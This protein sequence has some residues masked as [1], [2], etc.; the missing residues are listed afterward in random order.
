MLWLLLIGRIESIDGSAV[1][2]EDY[3]P[4]DQVVDFGEGELEKQVGEGFI[5]S[6]LAN[7][8]FRKRTIQFKRAVS[9]QSLKYNQEFK[10]KAMGNKGQ[11][12]AQE[13]CLRMLIRTNHRLLL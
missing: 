8:L 12:K 13:G 6:S 2:G 4:I 10:N 5:D 7:L 9:Q 1:S 11:T 3:I